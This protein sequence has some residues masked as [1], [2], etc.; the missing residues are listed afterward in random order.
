MEVK[1]VRKSK[2]TIPAQRDTHAPRVPLRRESKE[3]YGKSLFAL[4]NNVVNTLLLFS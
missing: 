1:S 2:V 3:A 4:T